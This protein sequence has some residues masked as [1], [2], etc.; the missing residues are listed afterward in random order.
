M[1]K[2]R[3]KEILNIRLVCVFNNFNFFIGGDLFFFE[4]ILDLVFLR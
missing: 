3:L 1:K 4:V 2:N